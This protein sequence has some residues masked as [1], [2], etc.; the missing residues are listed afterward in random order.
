MVW[1]L[2]WL[3]EAELPWKQRKHPSPPS[4]EGSSWSA[5]LH[6]N[7]QVN[8][9]FLVFSPLFK[10]SEQ[11]SFMLSVAWGLSLLSNL[12]PWMFCE[13]IFI[14]VS[15]DNKRWRHV[16]SDELI[17]KFHSC[18]VSEPE[19]LP[20]G[21]AS[22]CPRVGSAALAFTAVPLPPSC[23]HLEE[24][25]LIW[26]R[27]SWLNRKVCFKGVKCLKALIDFQFFFF[28]YDCLG[29]ILKTGLGMSKHH[30][31]LAQPRTI[32]RTQLIMCKMKTSCQH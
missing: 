20:E 23:G 25:H 12:W 8:S 11:Q 28:F 9:F 30:T 32:C 26:T 7:N 5:D 24:L 17:H 10:Q 13:G 31:Q 15:V 14:G 19:G 16:L 22:A 18:P 3:S 6:V 27:F 21:G 29:T 1:L 2:L 4:E